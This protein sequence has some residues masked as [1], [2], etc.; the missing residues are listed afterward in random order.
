MKTLLH[1]TIAA[2]FLLLGLH[3][4]TYGNHPTK[5]APKPLETTFKFRQNKG[6]WP[7]AVR[8]RVD[9]P[10]GALFL[11]QNSL[12]YVFLNPDQLKTLH[13]K[14][15][16][17]DVE[18]IDGH[19]IRV[20]FLG[21][22]ANPAVNGA[23][24]FP[25][26]ENYFIGNDPSHWASKVGVF[27]Q[28]QYSE[29]YPGI[30]LAFYSQEKQL[31]YDFIVAP[32]ANP[33]RIQLKYSGA[34]S[35]SLH[36]GKL[37][38]QT[39]VG[40]VQEHIPLAY[41]LRNGRR[42]PVQ[43]VYQLLNESTVGFQFPRGYNT[44]L[45]LVIDPT[46]VFSTY[47]GSFSDNWG[48]TAAYDRTGALYSGG[49]VSGP[50]YIPT[51]GAVQ[52]LYGNGG[53]PVLDNNVTLGYRCDMALVKYNASGTNIEYATFL[54]G[55]NN[56]LPTSL[57]VN[58]QN[59]LY[60][61]GITR[62]DN[63]P[64]SFN[65]YDRN[66]NG[67][68][69]AR[70]ARG[71]ID[72]VVSKISA[73]GS[74][75]VGSTFVGGT[76][77][78]GVNE[79]DGLLYNFYADDSRGDIIV[80][81]LGNCFVVSSTKSADFP[82]TPGC[83]QSSLRGT[84]D[85]V[86]FK[87]NPDLSQLVWSTYIG[88]NG[89]EA[90]YN[91]NFDMRGGLYA[92][93]G[94]TSLNF[95]TTTGAWQTSYQGGRSDG[96]VVH[97]SSD[98]QRLLQATY[99]GTDQYDQTY[100]VDTDAD[101]E[102]YFLGQTEGNYPSLGTTYNNP[103]GKQFITK[104]K[105]DLSAP[106]F[107][108]KFGTGG[109]TPDITFTAFLVDKCEN[110]YLAGW[111]GPNFPG[112]GSTFGLEI[113][114]DAI[115][116]TTDGSDFYLMVLDKG[117]N[118][119]L[120]ATYF[121]GDLTDDHVDGGTSRFDKYGIMYHSV[122]A[123][124]LAGS[125]DDFPTTPGVVSRTN[126]AA[127][128][129]NA[130]FK[131]EFD[132]IDATIAQYE[133]DT[134]TT[135]GCVPFTVIFQNQSVGAE[136]Y[137]WDFGDGSATSTEVNPTHIYTEPGIYAVKLVAF[138]PNKCNN[139]DTTLQYVF[140]YAPAQSVFDVDASACDLTVHLTN[141]TRGGTT[142]L[143]DFGDG[144]V[145]NTFQPGS[146]TYRRPGTY[147]I[148]LIV[149][150]NSW[151]NDTSFTTV[152]VG[153]PNV[154]RFVV[155]GGECSLAVQFENTTV[156]S[157]DFLWD[158]GDGTTSTERSPFHT[159]TSS[160]DYTIRLTIAPTLSCAQTSTQVIRVSGSGSKGGTISPAA[161][162]CF[163]QTSP[164]L[165]LNNQIGNVLRWEASKDDGRTW[166]P[167]GK[168]G[169]LSFQSGPLTVSTA[170]RAVVQLAVCPPAT[171]EPV[172][173]TVDP[174][175][176]RP[177]LM[178]SST[179]CATSTETVL[180]LSEFGS[181]RL[182]Q[183]EKRQ[184]AQ[185][186]Q[187]G[188]WNPVSPQTLVAPTGT[189]TQTTEYRA[190]FQAGNCGSIYSNVARVELNLP[191]VGGNVLGSRVVCFGGTSGDLTIN[192]HQGQVIGWQASKDAGANWTD[193]GKAGQQ[194]FVS[195]RLTVNT[196]FRAIVQSTGC[197]S[198][199]SEPA[200][201]Q[202][203]RAVQVGRLIGDTVACTSS[204]AQNLQLIGSSGIVQQWESRLVDDP[205]SPW[206]IFIEPSRSIHTGPLQQSRMYRALIG[207]GVCTPVYTNT[208][209]VR[210][211][212]PSLAGQ[213]LSDGTI[214]YG[215]KSTPLQVINQRGNI[216]RW[217]ASKDD[218]LHWTNLGKAAVNPFI[219]GRMTVNTMYRAVVQN[220]DCPVATTEPVRISVFRPNGPIDFEAGVLSSGS[221][222]VCPGASPTFVLT[223]ATGLISHWEYSFDDW[224]TVL[225][226][227]AMAT[228]VRLSVAQLSIRVRA[229]V[230]SPLCNIQKLSNEVTVGVYALGNISLSGT[231]HC[232]ELAT[233]TVA[234]D[235][236]PASDRASYHVLQ[237]STGLDRTSSTPVFRSLP[238]GNLAVE[239]RDA[240]S[241]LLRDTIELQPNIVAPVITKVERDPFGQV[242]LEWT[243]AGGSAARYRLFVRLKGTVQWQIIDNLTINR[244]SFINLERGAIYEAMVALICTDPLTGVSSPF[245]NQRTVEFYFGTESRCF[246]IQPKPP[247]GLTV[248]TITANTALV[249]WNHVVDM[250]RSQGY[251]LSFGPMSVNP[252]SWTQLNVCYPDS[253]RLIGGLIPNRA[254]G[255]RVRA[256]CS[257]CTTALQILDKRSDWS[258]LVTL[259]TLSLKSGLVAAENQTDPSS[260]WLL[261]PNPSQGRFQLMG[262]A[263]EPGVAIASVMDNTGRLVF[264]QEVNLIPG[265]NELSFEL[266][267][268]NRGIYLIQ[269]KSAAQRWSTKL[270]ID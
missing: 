138:N 93:G 26:F 88:G 43:C 231:A 211:N 182:V 209:T 57:V 4:E 256:N 199:F 94:T 35:I 176:P 147:N 101:D 63:F 22:N 189:L 39:S 8:Y 190:L 267:H 221:L 108:L 9:I 66:F 187:W 270:V 90:G 119:L 196:W 250:G 11:E 178:G 68:F 192:Q 59:E 99:V 123:S 166:V 100:F 133:Y 142:Y 120:Y 203:T 243:A 117:G 31:K 269:L 50:D 141:R 38:I 14:G 49:I 21:A 12:N 197:G 25:Y 102:V 254:Y 48:M 27:A 260:A 44:R 130:S 137:L 215:E 60:V 81:G 140:V 45:P 67:T 157:G 23:Q 135:L 122:C 40:V 183:W 79:R 152:T 241:C 188:V 76:A 253:Q 83:F 70:V 201:I 54:G 161:T 266:L 258:R 185:S 169:E 69:D 175:A 184:P 172:L 65:A 125:A 216:V 28:A 257:N 146:Y 200:I 153:T 198:A 191:A 19:V 92:V 80:D 139:S 202:V 242:N 47:T 159:Y 42:I 115:Q 214:C 232:G 170:F 32:Q 195:G 82:T 131:F 212:P 163:G 113:T 229:V 168:A 10:A 181:A 6:Q 41:Q 77:F 220:L 84:Q 263:I 85:A 226:S 114:P 97:A 206:E 208:V 110:I 236:P 246:D 223:G 210:V 7:A 245:S 193:L 194:T 148:R 116:R 20:D 2:L 261:Y 112:G 58:D 249:R 264:E 158:F 144:T 127:N 259:Q 75:L 239:A 129:N 98:G 106:V 252:L 219:S 1:L 150:T 51:P 24:P 104:L 34:N 107:S 217:E 89:Y 233:L 222:A 134:L 186:D 218:G 235:P 234:V 160:G 53:S 143:W 73:D 61:L 33:S 86:L 244:H 103:A 3:Q 204:L 240:N 155:N 15:Q 174:N 29:L 52:V 227:P 16:R 165:N 37:L 13:P 74:L 95:P 237:A 64:T 36:E 87:M 180:V 247:G 72:I 154:P 136:S 17:P 228:T 5:P 30:D 177:I 126:N 173:I 109:P 18:F 265:Q 179:T 55:R 121:G 62:S 118:N 268:L 71:D 124:C 262:E 149:N 205:N 91:L 213:L 255:V 171:S 156:G 238:F 248:V 132:I 145:T 56:E 162:V 105:P 251:I 128:C 230:R 167:L 46:L 78:D 224:A 225:R 164:V 111:G 207:N 151:C 96:F